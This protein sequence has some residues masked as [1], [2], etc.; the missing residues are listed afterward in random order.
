MRFVDEENQVVA[1]FDFVD[2]AL[3]TFF[4]HS[5]QHGAGN[6]PAHL[7]LDHV[8]V[9]QT[10]R[11]LLRLQLDHPGEAFDHGSLADARF[12]NQHRRVSALAMT[13]NFDDLLNLFFAANRGRNLVGPSHPIQ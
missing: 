1:L 2:D 4:K 10:R 3:D 12:P 8:R 6:Y 11:N 13:K 5:A 7:Q 9:S